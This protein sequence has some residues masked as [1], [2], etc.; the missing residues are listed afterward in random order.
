M[1]DCL[2]L[3]ISSIDILFSSDA[4]NKY[5]ENL[6]GWAIYSQETGPLAG[7]NCSPG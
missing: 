4:E 5:D 6:G 7:T 1:E 2:F 3:Q